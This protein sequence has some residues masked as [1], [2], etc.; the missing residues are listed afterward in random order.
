MK[1]RARDGREGGGGKV[2]RGANYYANSYSWNE[3]MS[4]VGCT[5][6]K[7]AITV[8]DIISG[9]NPTTQ[10]FLM[11]LVCFFPLSL[12][13]SSRPPVVPLPFFHLNF[14]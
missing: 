6:T 7:D 14:D 2:I 9:P 5:F 1:E 3:G 12:P 13:P 10:S 4:L 8:K 11:Y